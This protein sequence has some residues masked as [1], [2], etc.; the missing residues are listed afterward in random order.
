MFSTGR[1]HIEIFEGFLL[2]Y[3][4]KFPSELPDIVVLFDVFLK[5]ITI[6]GVCRIRQLSDETEVRSETTYINTYIDSCNG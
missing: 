5:F 6:N 2:E 4:V 1:L 3:L